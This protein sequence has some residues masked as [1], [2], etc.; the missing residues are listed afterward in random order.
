MEALLTLTIGLPLAIVLGLALPMLLWLAYSRITVGLVIVLA[1]FFME[2]V[3][4]E[5][6]GFWVGMYIYPTDLVFA[7]LALAALSRLFIAGDF[8]G[9]SLPWLLFGAVVVVS[10][11]LGLAQFGKAAGTDFRNYF[12]VWICALYFMSFP[13]DPARTQAIVRVW[14]VFAGLLLGLACFRWVAEFSGMPIAATWRDGSKAEEFRVLPSGA[15]LYLVN[16]L[17]ILA[18]AIAARVAKR[19]VWVAVPVLLVAILVLQHRS[20]WIAAAAGIAAMYVVFPGQIRLKLA[21]PIVAAVAVVV[22]VS[23]TLTAYGRLDTLMYKVGE[24]AATATDLAGGT[25]GGRLYGWHQLL[26]QLEPVEYAIGKPFGSGYE[27]YEFPNVRWKATYDPHNFYLQTLLRSG[28]IGLALLL[29]TYVVTFRRLLRHRD[30]P[31]RLALP[32]RLV[33][34]M[35]VTQMA[36][37]LTYRMPYEQVVWLGLAVGIAASLRRPSATG[38]ASLLGT[39]EMKPD[40]L[41]YAGGLGNLVRR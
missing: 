14:L 15:A 38:G 7:F 27:R 25:S 34:V 5:Y 41:E 19:W 12:Y 8:P 40:P 29:M 26:L 18:Y 22:V 31:G 2:V 3:Y 28:A 24:S 11:A 39:A 30:E 10:F 20:V 6:P 23:G 13:V 21:R 33:V 17:L 36:Y 35:L 1:T 32:P 9:R 16:T 37:I 4:I